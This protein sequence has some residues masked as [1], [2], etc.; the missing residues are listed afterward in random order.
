VKLLIN[1]KRADLTKKYGS[2]EIVEKIMAKKIWLGMTD[3]MA[4]ESWGTPDDINR[5][6][7][8]WG[9][10]EQW[11]YGNTYVYFENGILTSAYS[12]DFGHSVLLKADSQS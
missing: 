5:T 9:V 11:I 7:G 8:S 3:K 10:H 1:K 2:L 6:V 12:C 4:R